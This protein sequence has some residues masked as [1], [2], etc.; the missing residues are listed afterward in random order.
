MGFPG[1]PDVRSPVL[2]SGD[3]S[4]TSNTGDEPERCEFRKGC[5]RLGS[6]PF[7]AE[8]AEMRQAQQVSQ[9]RLPWI[10]PVWDPSP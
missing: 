3:Y 9:T 10:L 8:D 2:S 6:P 4:S 1:L 5:Q 7:R